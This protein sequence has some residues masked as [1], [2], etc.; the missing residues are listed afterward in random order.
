[1]L[2]FQ[3]ICRDMTK[4]KA[5]ARECAPVILRTSLSTDRCGVGSKIIIRVSLLQVPLRYRCSYSMRNLFFF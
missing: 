2:L 3:V 5:K 4:V 1:M